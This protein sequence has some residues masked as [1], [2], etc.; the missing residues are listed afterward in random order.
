VLATV[1]GVIA[2]VLRLSNNWIV[3]RLMTVYV[4]VFRNIPTLLWILIFGAIMTEAMPAPSAFRGDDPAASMIFFDRRHHQP[5]R[6]RAR[7]LF[8]RSLGSSTSA[9]SRS[10]ST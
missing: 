8:S 6:L 4:E 10:A 5:R 2:G 3:A 9:A 1:V 7:A